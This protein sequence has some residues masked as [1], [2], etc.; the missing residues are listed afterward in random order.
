MKLIQLILI[1]LLVSP[2]S[3]LSD[4]KK[5]E[6]RQRDTLR[7]SKVKDPFVDKDGD[8]INDLLKK[9][10]KKHKVVEDVLDV[11]NKFLETHSYKRHRR[12]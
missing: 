8:G 1:L 3:L 2:A 9:R 10:K 12:H 11:L 6:P 5:E 7:I 4:D